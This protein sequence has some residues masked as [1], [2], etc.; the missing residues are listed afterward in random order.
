M[1]AR[2][3]LQAYAGDTF[4]SLV[5]VVTVDPGTK[6]ETPVDFTGAS[7]RMAIKAK[8]WV[9]DD[10]ALVLLTSTPAAGLSFPAAGQIRIELTPDQTRAL[11]N[12]QL[13][14]DLQVTYATGKVQ[15]CL[16]GKFITTYDVTP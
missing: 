16:V 13:H 9:T 8:P 7:A 15:T 2:V 5:L 14:Y 1:P 4:E 12:T 10:Q 3:D 11:I 6:A